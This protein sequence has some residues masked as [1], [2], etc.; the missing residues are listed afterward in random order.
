MIS[1]CVC[2]HSAP[3]RITSFAAFTDN[4]LHCAATT[5]KTIVSRTEMEACIAPEKGTSSSDASIPIVLVN[6]RMTGFGDEVKEDQ[7][8]GTLS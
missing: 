4:K 5:P 8:T 1:M 3:V 6:Q 2:M 7:Q